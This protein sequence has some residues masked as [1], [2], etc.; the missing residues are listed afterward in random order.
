MQ[1]CMQ[2]RVKPPRPRKILHIWN[3]IQLIFIAYLPCAIYKLHMYKNS[4]NIKL[5]FC[6][7]LINV[8]SNVVK[9][10]IKVNII[11]KTPFYVLIVFRYNE[12]IGNNLTIID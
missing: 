12:K 4:N 3:I 6:D 1:F 7:I 11:L 8:I 2:G 9:C 10:L 5:T